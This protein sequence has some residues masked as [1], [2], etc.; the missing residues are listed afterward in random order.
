MK[1]LLI[2]LRKS[3]AFPLFL[4]V[5]IIGAVGTTYATTSKARSTSEVHEVV[6]T[7]NTFSVEQTAQADVQT[8]YTW[9]DKEGKTYPIYVTKRG[10]CY[11]KRIS[12]KT[13][14][15]YKYYLPKETQAQIKRELGV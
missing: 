7:G 9:K 13:G 5:L 11:I 15:E 8:P 1:K 6:R 14:K 10:A 4:T 12:K 3:F 2:N